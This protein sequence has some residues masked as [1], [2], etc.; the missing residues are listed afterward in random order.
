MTPAP[1]PRTE[2][3]TPPTPLIEGV[4]LACQ[5]CVVPRRQRRFRFVPPAYVWFSPRPHEHGDG[6]QLEGRVQPISHDVHHDTDQGTDQGTRKRSFVA[7]LLCKPSLRWRI[8]SRCSPP[9][10]DQ[11]RQ[12]GAW[13]RC[14]IPHR[15]GEAERRASR[16]PSQRVRKGRR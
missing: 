7:A 13:R 9:M 14:P 16:H 6:E 12:R 1:T 3:N 11:A 4:T 15:S 2:D 5:P 8:H 10:S